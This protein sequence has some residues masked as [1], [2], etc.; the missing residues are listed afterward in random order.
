M[1]INIVSTILCPFSSRPLKNGNDLP[2]TYRWIYVLSWDRAVV[3]N[4]A[5]DGFSTP[6]AT[7]FNVAK[8][9]FKI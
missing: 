1:K 9:Q 6:S 7:Q 3:W 4:C 5:S 2:Q 8:L